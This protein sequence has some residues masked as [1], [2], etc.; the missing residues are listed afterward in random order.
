MLPLISIVI[1]TWNRRDS[2]IRCLNS[3][4]SQDFDNYEI[5]IVDDGSTDGTV[6]ALDSYADYHL[7]ILKHKENRGV[8]AARHT[9]TAASS[10]QWIISID[11]DA[12]ILPL[13]LRLMAD[14]VVMAPKNVG[15]LLFMVYYEKLGSLPEGFICAGPVNNLNIKALSP[16]NVFSFGQPFGLKSYMKW[17]EKNICSAAFI[18]HRREVFDRVKWPTDRRLESQFHLQVYKCWD[19][20]F[21]KDVVGVFFEDA[22]LAISSDRSE[23]G[24][25]RQMDS[26]ID[27]A[28]S[29][30][31]VI[32]EFGVEMKE[33]APKLYYTVL[34]NAAY[35]YFQSG[36]RSSGLHFSLLA[37]QW[38]PFA[39]QVYPLI[40]AGLAGPAVIRIL[41]KR[42]RIRNYARR[43]IFRET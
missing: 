19:G 2:V 13:G 42:A 27:R 3:I 8:C 41:R 21:H 33:W 17:V 30:R 15:S 38:R 34:W 16:D 4:I 40:I 6:L 10:G 26:A 29:Y 37:M 22:P 35:Q 36:K 1:P 7:K 12:V 9:G 31:E 43:I 20:I 18:C 5:I 25:R 32:I 39:L 14:K 11:S 23:T 24:I 28:Q